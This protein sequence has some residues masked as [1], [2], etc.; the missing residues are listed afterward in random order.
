MQRCIYKSLN[1]ALP[2]VPQWGSGRDYGTEEKRRSKCGN[3]ERSS[4]YSDKWE[5]ENLSLQH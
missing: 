4:R 1:T 5:K 2:T 3:T